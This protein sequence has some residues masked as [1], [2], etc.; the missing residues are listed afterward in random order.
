MVDL[1]DLDEVRKGRL[2]HELFGE[3]VD[4]RPSSEDCVFVHGDYCLPNIFFKGD[5]L[6]GFVDLGRCG[7]A[8]RYQDLAL[9]CR[10]LK[11]NLGKDM[12][13]VVTDV[14]GRGLLDPERLDYYCLLDEFF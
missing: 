1:D 11:Y 8:D 14:Y 12:V 3:L 13:K 5:R 4:R 6:T 9:L 2:G 10:S 7:M